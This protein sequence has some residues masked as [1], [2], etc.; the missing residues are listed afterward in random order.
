MQHFAAGQIV[1]STCDLKWP[2]QQ[3]G[4][5]NPS[6]WHNTW[7]EKILRLKFTDKEWIS[8]KKRRFEQ[9]YLVK[10]TYPLPAA[11]P[12]SW[13]F[14]FE[15]IRSS[16]RLSWSTKWTRFFTKKCC[17]FP[18]WQYSTISN[19]SPVREK[20]TNQCPSV[21]DFSSNEFSKTSCSINLVGKCSNFD[22][23]SN[24]KVSMELKK[25]VNALTF[26]NIFSDCSKQID[27]I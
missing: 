16:S 17:K 22:V 12:E 13:G 27:D 25:C 10:A 21:G 20:T 8:F 11:T 18:N 26:W 23:C 1:H 4:G 24:W 15:S 6:Y 5:C 7:N 9:I 3:I 14:I 19:N 2:R